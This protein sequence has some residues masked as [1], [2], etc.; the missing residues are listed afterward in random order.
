MS[1]Y[2][3]KMIIDRRGFADASLANSLFL[4]DPR[5]YGIYLNHVYTDEVV[6]KDFRGVPTDQFRFPF[7]YFNQG[8]KGTQA[9]IET[10]MYRADGQMESAYGDLRHQLVCDTNNGQGYVTDKYV[11]E[12]TTTGGLL[13]APNNGSGRTG[14][15]KI[16]RGTP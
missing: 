5:A 2:A 16:T 15:V 6:R 8:A 11:F 14:I 7:V 13:F 1:A 4:V 9:T 10:L 12:H 3:E